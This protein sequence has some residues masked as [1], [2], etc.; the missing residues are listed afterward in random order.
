MVRGRRRCRR[1]PR[2]R[3]RSASAPGDLRAVRTT[4]RAVGMAL[5]ADAG[6]A[7]PPRFR[8]GGPGA[9][10]PLRYERD[11]SAPAAAVGQDRQR[12]LRREDRP[13]PV[14][15]AVDGGLCS[16]RAPS[17]RARHLRDRRLF[18]RRTPAGDR[19][20][21]RA[22][23]PAARG[24]ASGRSKCSRSCRCGC[25][26]RGAFGVWPDAIPR[27]AAVRRGADRRG[28]VRLDGRSADGYRNAC[29][30]VAGAPRDAGRSGEGAQGGVSRC[31]EPSLKVV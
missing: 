4:A 3:P 17:G 22:R 29:G 28:H 10:D 30:V 2:R 12:S 7:G 1:H 13:P 23:R 16:A 21:P 11:R 18:R 26:D 5:V 31:P 14:C 25:G 20:S 8:V 19:H 24:V 27:V 9:V 6:G 15:D